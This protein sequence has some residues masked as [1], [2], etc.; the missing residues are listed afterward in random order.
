MAGQRS[1]SR[2]RKLRVRMA[3]T[4][5]IP[6]L[7]EDD[8]DSFAPDN[9]LVNIIEMELISF[10]NL[11][12][13]YGRD[14]RDDRRPPPR[15]HIRRRSLH[16]DHTHFPGQNIS[17]IF[18][19]MGLIS[20]VDIGPVELLNLTVHLVLLAVALIKRANARTKLRLKLPLHGWSS[21]FGPLF[22]SH[23]QLLL[24][25]TLHCQK[26]LLESPTPLE[27]TLP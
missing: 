3:N 2:L 6:V 24:H 15:R 4:S 1:S 23:I 7:L 9:I 11:A 8:D 18:P 5:E 26:S 21:F 17:V 10:N 27:W 22:L 16:N 12:A 20:V 25:L 19:A 14:R 13:G